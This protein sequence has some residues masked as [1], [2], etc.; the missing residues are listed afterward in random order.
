MAGAADDTVQFSQA[1]SNLQLPWREFIS[2]T[3]STERGS[4]SGA[5]SRVSMTLDLNWSD[6]GKAIAGILGY[7][8]INNTGNSGNIKDINSKLSR[9]LPM[10][11]PYWTWLYATEIV[12]QHGVNW[13]TKGTIVTQAQF[14]N[15]WQQGL[16]GSVSTY[17]LERYT[18]NFNAL[19]YDVVSDSNLGNAGDGTGAEYNR[20]VV[21]ISKPTTQTFAFPGGSFKFANGPNAGAPPFTGPFAIRT[22]RRTVSWTWM[23]VPE[24]YIFNSAGFASN[25]EPCVGRINNA[26]FAGYPIHTLYLDSVD[27]EPIMFPVPPQVLGLPKWHPPRGF[28]V[29]FNFVYFNPDPDNVLSDGWNSAPDR[30]NATS[31]GV[32][33]WYKAVSVAPTG[34]TGSGGATPYTDANFT[35][36]F[37]PV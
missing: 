11:H 16:E 35:T 36:M 10:Q 24:Y 26:A 2:R 34:A 3:G 25:I 8:F 23:L 31:T 28:N 29:R 1:G 14:P 27:Y 9:V 4:W 18:I 6:R 37:N 15:G 33:K 22:M 30:S 13:S 7:A 19:P 12:D 21:Q 5:A 20:Y 17:G 32:I